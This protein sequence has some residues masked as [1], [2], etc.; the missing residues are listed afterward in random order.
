M[1]NLL[2]KG[3]LPD[4]EKLITA[5]NTKRMGDPI[6]PLEPAAAKELQEY[7]AK[8]R[9]EKI[10]TLKKTLAIQTPAIDQLSQQIRALNEIRQQK[11][12]AEPIDD[13]MQALHAL[14]KKIDPK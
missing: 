14:V 11:E 9:Q 4:I 10:E 3:K 1:R 5:A 6:I 12:K 13:Q 2:K 8:E 7:L